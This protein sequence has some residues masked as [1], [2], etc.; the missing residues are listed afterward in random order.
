MRRSYVGAGI[1]SITTHKD[2]QCTIYTQ[3][4]IIN[5]RIYHTHILAYCPIDVCVYAGLRINLRTTAYDTYIHNIRIYLRIQY[6][7][8][9]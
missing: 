9:A 6:Y 3:V 8:Y 2:L 1:L 7:M 4:Y 5:I